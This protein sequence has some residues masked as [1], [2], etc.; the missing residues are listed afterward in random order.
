MSWS[1]RSAGEGNAGKLGMKLI[2][3]TCKCWENQMNIKGRAWAQKTCWKKQASHVREQERTGENHKVV[4][5]ELRTPVTGV[6]ERHGDGRSGRGWCEGAGWGDSGEADQPLQLLVSHN[7]HF[8]DKLCQL[9]KPVVK[10]GCIFN[11]RPECWV[12]TSLYFTGEAVEQ[13][14]AELA[15]VESIGQMCQGPQI[16]R[17]TSKRA[18]PSPETCP[19]I[20]K[21]VT[22]WANIQTR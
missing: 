13:L 5:L 10:Q 20:H 16:S 8:P 17:K 2:N 19:Q 11:T 21:R 22:L 6:L 3:I 18:H 15:N 12:R 1:R 7:G 14:L 4:R 9:W